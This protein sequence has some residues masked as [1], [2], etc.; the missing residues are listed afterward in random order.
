MGRPKGSKNKPRVECLPPD[1]RPELPPPEEKHS[2]VID[3][4]IK[5][6][7]RPNDFMDDAY[8]IGK[9]KDG[10]TYVAKMYMADK[11]PITNELK[12]KLGV[13]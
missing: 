8:V 9:R 1:D 2:E 10:T 7:T 6:I 5:V 3:V 4:T 13:E 11:V 12:K